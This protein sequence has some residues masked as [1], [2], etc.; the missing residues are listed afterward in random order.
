MEP[1]GIPNFNR[2]L[3]GIGGGAIRAI[4]LGLGV[5]ATTAI[6][7]IAGLVVIGLI[8]IFLR[9]MPLYALIGI[10]I[11][12]CYMIYSSERSYRYAEKNP[13]PAL[14]GGG[15]LLQYLQS[16]AGAKD[17]K[18]IRGDSTPVAGTIVNSEGGHDAS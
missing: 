5:L 17:P 18:T 8:A 10:A 7:N 2:L 15:A 16:Q 9:G 6:Q 4:K 3:T 1:D 11:V 14:L 12:L 13:I